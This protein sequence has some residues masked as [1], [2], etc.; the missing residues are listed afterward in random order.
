MKRA[1]HCGFIDEDEWHE[2]YSG[3]PYLG[4]PPHHVDLV[5][6]AGGEPRDKAYCPGY[7]ARLPLVQEAWR[8]YDARKDNLLTALYPRTE[9]VILEATDEVMRALRRHENSVHKKQA[10]KNKQHNR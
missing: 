9:L 3:P 2:E 7:L 4:T 1:Y 6:H 10:D 5:N 8:A